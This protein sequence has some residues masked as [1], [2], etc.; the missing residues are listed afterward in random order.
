M[1]ILCETTVYSPCGTKREIPKRW[2]TSMCHILNPDWCLESVRYHCSEM[3]RLYT[4]FLSWRGRARWQRKWNLLTSGQST[5]EDTE[6]EFSR[7]DTAPFM[8]SIKCWSEQVCEK[9]IWGNNDNNNTTPGIAG[10]STWGLQS[11]YSHQV[12]WEPS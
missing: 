7:S 12:D 5:R 3:Q 4:V 2:K 8:Y 1:C 9:A 6:R 11:A 10:N